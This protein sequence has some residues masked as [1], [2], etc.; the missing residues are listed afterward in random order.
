MK[1]QRVY[2]SSVCF[3]LSVLCLCEMFY[4]LSHRLTPDPQPTDSG[5]PLARAELL[6]ANRVH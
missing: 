1:D 4:R 5:A 3:S 6:S 2:W